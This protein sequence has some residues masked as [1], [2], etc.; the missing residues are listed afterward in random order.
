MKTQDRLTGHDTTRAYSVTID[1]RQNNNLSYMGTIL[2]S[3]VSDLEHD[4]VCHIAPP[5]FKGAS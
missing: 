5:S 3:N 4:S 2:K 1:M